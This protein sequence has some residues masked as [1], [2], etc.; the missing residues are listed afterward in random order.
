MW[1]RKEGFGRTYFSIL[2]FWVQKDNV[3]CTPSSA[4]SFHHCS[5]ALNSWSLP[6]HC[7]LCGSIHLWCSSILPPFLPGVFCYRFPPGV[8]WTLPWSLLIFILVPYR[9]FLLLSSLPQPTF[10]K[11]QTS[12]FGTDP[13]RAPDMHIQLLP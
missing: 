13:A 11:Y 6:F 4:L 7:R 5:A 1:T 8:P 3:S 10:C 2:F 9:C 12:V